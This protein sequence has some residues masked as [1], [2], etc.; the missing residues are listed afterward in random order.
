M[1]K[2]KTSGASQHIGPRGKRLGNKVVSGQV[3]EPGMILVRQ[4]GTKITAGDG[5]KAGRDFTLY[6]EVQGVVKF[7]K[8]L[9]RKI[10]SV[11]SQ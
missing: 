5:V 1:A 11:F 2:K 10:V 6:S 4:K 7:G 9:G 3:V 8:K